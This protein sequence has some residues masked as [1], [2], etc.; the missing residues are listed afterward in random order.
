MKDT[1]FNRAAFLSAKQ[2]S[3]LCLDR[4]TKKLGS[5]I[6]DISKVE[7][8]EEKVSSIDKFNTQYLE[9][10][11]ELSYEKLNNILNF[12]QKL[13]IPRYMIEAI[14]LEIAKKVLTSG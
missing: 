3:R 10:L 1:S 4:T 6:K 2:A 9:F 12:R 13:Y 7:S 14:E 8:E 11:S 5:S